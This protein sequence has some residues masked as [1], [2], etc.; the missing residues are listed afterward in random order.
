[1]TL[2]DFLRPGNWLNDTAGPRDVQLRRRLEEG[3][4]FRGV[5]ICALKEHFDG[6]VQGSGFDPVADFLHLGRACALNR[7]IRPHQ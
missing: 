7:C 4:R 6:G 2:V 5:L 3:S 1:M